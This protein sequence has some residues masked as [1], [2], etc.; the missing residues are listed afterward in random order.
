MLGSWFERSSTPPAPT[1]TFCVTGITWRMQKTKNKTTPL[2][3]PPPKERKKRKTK[4]R[5]IKTNKQINNHKDPKNK[6]KPTTNKNKIKTGFDL[7]SLHRAWD[8]ISACNVLLYIVFV[9]LVADK[10]KKKMKE[11]R[12]FCVYVW[13]VAFLLQIKNKKVKDG[14]KCDCFLYTFFLLHKKRY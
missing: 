2:P 5:N 4:Q 8:Q 12:L 6:Q 10:K 7:N 1:H 11:M 9:V 13:L 14:R 3:P